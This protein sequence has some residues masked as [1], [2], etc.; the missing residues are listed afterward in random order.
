MSRR[1]PR[2]RSSTLAASHTAVPTAEDDD[3]GC[4]WHMSPLWNASILTTWT[5]LSTGAM[6]GGAP[7]RLL[8]SAGRVRAAPAH[9]IKRPCRSSTARAAFSARSLSS[10]LR[11][12]LQQPRRL[13][14]RSAR[15]Y[16]LLGTTCTVRIYTGGDA[17]RNRRRFRAPRADRGADVRD[18]RRQ[19]GL[20]GQRR[21][22]PEAG[23]GERGRS[24]GGQDRAAVLAA[25][26]MVHSTSPWSPW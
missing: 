15:S 5:E 20:P 9:A 18:P 1:V 24:R 26:G 21:G 13:R 19:R 6:F 10:S 4:L 22:R 25:R 16:D 14:R 2:R 11:P 3:A 23:D 17:R 8:Q 7:G 12:P